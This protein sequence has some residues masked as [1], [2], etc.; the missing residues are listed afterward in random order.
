MSPPVIHGCPECGNT[1]ES[2]PVCQR[3]AIHCQC[4]EEE[5]KA[6][7]GDEWDPDIEYTLPG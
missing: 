7:A 3:C 2:C 6:P 1:Y 4:D 5:V